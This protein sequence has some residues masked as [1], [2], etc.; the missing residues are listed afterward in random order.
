MGAIFA[1]GST[2]GFIA[3]FFRS[4]PKRSFLMVG[5]LIFAGFAEGVG[6][7]TLLPVL[8]VA[9]GAE[10]E[11]PSRIG[12]LVADG[13]GRIGL[14]ASLG[15]LL[16]LLVL[17]MGLK[18]V[19]RWAAMRQVGY[20]VAQLATDLRLRLL[21]AIMRSRWSHFTSQSTGHF[22]N[23][24]GTEAH[25][26]SSA[27]RE[28]CSAI[29]GLVEVS[30]YLVVVVIVS[31][32]VGLMALFGGIAIVWL[33][34]SLI[35]MSRQAGYDQTEL[36]KSLIK[37]L[38]EVL[39]GIKPVKAMGRENDLLPILEEETNSFNLAQQRSVLASETLRSF[40]EPIMVLMIAIG[41]FGALT[42]GNQPFS[43]VLLLAF[44][45]YRVIT[46]VNNLQNQ[47]QVVA[48]GESAFWS[49]HQ[50]VVEAE[51]AREAT[52]GF[53]PPPTLRSGIRVE[54]VRFAYDER[55][56]LNDVSLWIPAGS[57]VSLVG[58]SGSGKTTLADLITGLHRPQ[59][60][61]IYLDDMPL[62][63]LDLAAW[64]SKIGYVPQET[65]LF[66]QSVYRNVTLGRDDFSEE[67]VRRALTNAGA[68]EF[69]TE[70]PNGLEQNIGEL[71]SMISGGQRQRIAI[72]RALVGDP[73]LLILDEATT[74]LDPDTERA[75]CDT[76]QEL[77]GSVTILAISHQTALKEAAEVVYEVAAGSVRRIEAVG[78]PSGTA[79]GAV[80][81]PSRSGSPA[82]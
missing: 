76:L 26:A 78:T 15:V 10:G 48:E 57:F 80:T 47:Y 53:L 21:R 59:S 63:D 5:L 49:L 67:E 70:M 1:S 56:V 22:A 32:Q 51:D 69:V 61:E 9:V 65:L 12:L 68:W 39:P 33:L 2:L 77:R 82:T 62:S 72:A 35:Q 43:T 18:G 50:L 60:G 13:L 25:R 40:Q 79:G 81:N 37:R 20:T 28:A 23:A 24:V 46:T 42:W 7:L 34:H 71:G 30:L 29:A 4:Y 66:N 17:A 31:W 6:I 58:P 41:L 8:E 27:Y 3:Y 14:P 38:T 16:T 73:E 54:R 45:F 19:F 75:I 36:K 44:L 52:E 55:P 74:A 64:R 11:E